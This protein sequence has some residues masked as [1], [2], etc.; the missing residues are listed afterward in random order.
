MINLQQTKLQEQ[1]KSR[2]SRPWDFS[3]WQLAE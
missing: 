3:L 2:S 1:A